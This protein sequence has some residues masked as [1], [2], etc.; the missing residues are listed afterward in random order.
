MKVFDNIFFPQEKISSTEPTHLTPIQ[1][2]NAPL[3][4][5]EPING[6]GDLPTENGKYS[7]SYFF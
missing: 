4:E 6:N 3:E 2:E 5:K 7:S 1:L